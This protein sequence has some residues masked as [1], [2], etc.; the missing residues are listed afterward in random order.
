MDVKGTIYCRI[1]PIHTKQNKIY[2]YD[3]F[4]GLFSS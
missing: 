3:E 1:V 4:V 2:I